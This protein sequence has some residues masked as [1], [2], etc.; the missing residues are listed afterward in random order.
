METVYLH[1]DVDK[2]YYSVEALESP[3][4]ADERRAVIISVNPREYPRAVVTTANGVAR[5]IGIGSGMSTAIASRLAR[6]HGI[7]VVYVAPRHDVYA[8]Y[9]R[10]LM[11]LLRTETPLLEQRSIDEAALDWRHHGFRREPV[12]A[13]RRRILDE[14]GLSVSFGVAPTLLVAK[15]ASEVAKASDQHIWVVGPGEAAAFLAPL[16]VRALVG[17]GPKSEARL[18]GFEISTIGDL[19]GRP[20]EWLVDQFGTS[21]GRYLHRASRGEDNSTLVGERNSKSISA[22][23]TFSR[24]TADRGEIWLR[25]QA[26]AREVGERMRAE[27]LVASEVAIKVRYGATWETVTR[28]QRLARATDDPRV[29]AAAAAALMRKAWTHQPIRLIGLRAAKLG[30]RSNSVQLDLLSN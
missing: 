21:Y 5:S 29:L 24:D 8:V 7:E 13:L 23:H 19:A 3:A 27:N 28:Q 14:I 16:S 20:L 22:E 25:L 26:Q 4:L 18:R 15:M 2:M 11:D 10:R 6:E 17:I 12:S 1:C 30:A 9:S